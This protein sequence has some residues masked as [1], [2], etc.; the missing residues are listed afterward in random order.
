MILLAAAGLTVAIVPFS[1]D[2]LAYLEI[3]VYGYPQHYHRKAIGVVLLNGKIYF[4]NRVVCNILV[5]EN[6]VYIDIT[7]HLRS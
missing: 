4:A 7:D 2:Y 6:Q 1:I 3:F 5:D